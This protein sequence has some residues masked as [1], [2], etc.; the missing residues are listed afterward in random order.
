MSISSPTLRRLFREQFSGTSPLLV[1]QAARAEL[2]AE[3][4]NRLLVMKYVKCEER[5]Y[6]RDPQ[7]KERLLW[8]FAMTAPSSRFG[9]ASSSSFSIQLNQRNQ[10]T[11]AGWRIEALVSSVDELVAFVAACQDVFERTALQKEKRQK[12]RE[13]KAQAIGARVKAIAKEDKFDFYTHTDSQ[14]LTLFVRLSESESVELRI[15]FNKFEE[16]LPHLR[17]SIASV[18]ELYARGIKF[19]IGQSSPSG[20]RNQRW[21]QHDTL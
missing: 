10:L 14:K 11:I 4:S 2:T 6:Y 12:I 8:A 15:P 9:Y 1:T 17:S 20:W 18:R 5:H 16:V 13:L 19:K 7:E 21:I 3:I